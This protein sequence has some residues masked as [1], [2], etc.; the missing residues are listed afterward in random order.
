MYPMSAAFTAAVKQSHTVVTRAEIWQGGLF[1][2]DLEILSGKVSVDGGA[3][4]RRRCEVTLADPAGDLTPSDVSDLLGPFGS[5]VRLFRGVRLV[6][7]DPTSDELAPLGVFRLTNTRVSDSDQGLVIRLA[8]H[9]RARRIQR[10][11]WIDPYLIPGGVNYAQ[12]IQDLVADRAPG[13]AFNFVSSSRTAPP[14]ILGLDRDND[15]WKDAQD[16]ASALGCELFF[17]AA[18]V[19]VLRPIPD[20]NTSALSATYA[21]GAEATLLGVE[22]ELDA[23]QTYNG[24]IVTGEGSNVQV[25]VRS[26]RWDTDPDSPTYH[27]GDF[28]K[29]PYFLT[30][31]LI[32]TQAQA[33]AVA[34]AILRRILGVT[35][36]IRFDAIV[37]PA[38]DAGDVVKIKRLRAGVDDIHVVNALEV[39]LAVG[40]PMS[41]TTQKRKTV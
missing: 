3:A 17:D 29:V 31:S 16:M 19:C 25:P 38:H 5:E 11:R 6:E 33:D 23:E 20:P 12:A 14:I 7:G 2:R 24:A 10:A 15:P 39:P 32:T 41:A 36:R 28:G 34:S 1:V 27:L 13:V 4:I 21:E 9:D 26:E 22:R 8:G 40:D 37:N 30:S 35:E 18:G